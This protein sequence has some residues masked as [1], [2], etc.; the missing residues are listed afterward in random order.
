MSEQKKQF[1]KSEGDAWFARNQ[2]VL[3]SRDAHED[4][5]LRTILELGMQPKSLLEVGCAN[6]W[7][8]RALQKHFPALSCAGIDPSEQAIADA[9]LQTP[10]HDVQVGT[11]DVLPFADSAFDTLIYGFCL[12]LCD[13]ADLFK[14]AAEGDRVLADGGQLILYDF[15]T[16]TA[17]KNPYAHLEGTYAYKMDY[18]RLFDWHPAYARV[19][20]RFVHHD[21]AGEIP[22]DARI[23]ITVLQKNTRAAFPDN[24]YR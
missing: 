11:A 9:K 2:Q 13:R 1:L 8:L 24:P 14:I 22:M 21:G 16:E 19:H 17:Y 7:R 15:C 3:Q 18:A 5:V 10:A 4:D 20:H 12:Y 6:G 23:G